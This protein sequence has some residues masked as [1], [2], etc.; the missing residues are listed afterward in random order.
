MDLFLTELETGDWSAS[1]AWYRDVLGLLPEQIDTANCYVLFRAGASRLAL[2]AGNPRPGGVRLYFQVAD[3]DGELTRLATLGVPPEGEIK[4]SS[5][6][7]RRAIVHD[8]DG[9]DIGLF[10]SIS[11]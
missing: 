5:E 4:V 8:P 7:Y 10:E 6:G 1:V 3:L 2:K 9:Y 11:A